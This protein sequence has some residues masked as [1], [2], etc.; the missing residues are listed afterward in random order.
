[1]TYNYIV[2]ETLWQGIPV[3]FTFKFSCNMIGCCKQ[4]RG[5]SQVSSINNNKKNI[6][7][8]KKSACEHTQYTNST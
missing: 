8:N 3:Q 7:I 1:M 6:D 4:Y 2:K 5:F